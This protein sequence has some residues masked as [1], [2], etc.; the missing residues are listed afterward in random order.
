MKNLFPFLLCT[1][2]VVGL[3]AQVTTF[4]T[5]A[6]TLGV[7]A[8]YYGQEA[9]QNASASAKNNTYVGH[10]AGRYDVAGDNN[11]FFGTQ[12]GYKQES[13]SNNTYIGVQSGYV[14]G[15]SANNTCVGVQSGNNMELAKGNVFVGVRAGFTT[16][17]GGANVA[18]GY[19]AA[20]NMGNENG[21]TM[22]G[23][24]SGYSFVEGTDNTMLGK[25]AGYVKTG[26]SYNVFLGAEAGTKNVGGT[27]NIFLGYRAGFYET[28]SNQLY[29]ENSD[30]EVPLIYGDFRGDRVGINT[31]N[32][33]FGYTLAV[34]GK[35]M[36]EEV[37]V[38]L[39]E[40]WPDYVFDPD[41][42][43]MSITELKQYVAQ[44][45]HLPEIPSAQ[46]L[47]D[48]GGVDL[49]DMNHLL[50]KKV[51]ELSLYIIQLQEEIEILKQQ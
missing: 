46:E 21:N 15:G 51:E 12:A 27:G 36:A 39:S 32:V 8:S 3:S 18:L 25:R 2:V 13:G 14:G 6:G 40:N 34:D 50:L 7:A 29:I 23:H 11:S 24:Q 38:Q 20:Q 48:T 1:F 28:G 42:E 10:Q 47:A 22:I 17:S 26:G 30:K 37:R 45:R 49:G 9:G 35:V 31:K 33:P 41:Y 43:L 19:G 44:H 4:G 16:S 5:N